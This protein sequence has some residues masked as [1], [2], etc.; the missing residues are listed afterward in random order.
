MVDSRKIIKTGKIAELPLFDQMALALLFVF[1]LSDILGGAI[2]YYSVQFGLPWMVYAPHLLLTLALLPM[3]FA[4]LMSEGIKSTYLIVVALFSVAAIYGLF[5]LGSAAQVEVGLWALVPFLYGIVVFP[6]FIRGWRR[7]VPYATV[8]WALAVVGVLINF[9]YR[10]PWVG[11]EYQIAGITVRASQLWKTA[12]VNFVRLPGFSIDSYNTAP[13]IL[14]LALL[15]RATLPRRWWLPFWILSGAAIVLTTTKS[16]IVEYLLLSGP[17]T[18]RRGKV[19]AFWRRIPIAFAC[20]DI[21]LPFF[22]SFISEHSADSVQSPF[23]NLLIGSFVGRLAQGW[24]SWVQGIAAHGNAL[25][26]RG[27]GGVG[28]GQVVYEA[29]LFRHADNIAI[30]IYATFGVMGLVLLLFYAW[31]AGRSPGDRTLERFLFLCA[32]I[33]LVEGLVRTIVDYAFLGLAFGLTLRYWL[34][35][36]PWHRPYALTRRKQKAGGGTA[37]DSLPACT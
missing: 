32:C 33:V 18:Y 26:G 34:D 19:S 6:S 24:P 1:L 23:W 31:K 9:F 35:G 30:Y 15:L 21:T 5:N 37:G 10:W 13:Q 29:G 20:L 3:F 12:G 36:A 22:S 16:T 27:L 4:Y 7:L 17:W 14:L 11:F 2:R 8:L 28:R 25:L